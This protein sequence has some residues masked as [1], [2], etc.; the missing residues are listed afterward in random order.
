LKIQDFAKRKLRIEAEIQLGSTVALSTTS[1][2]TIDVA[3]ILWKIGGL[4]KI[5]R[6]FMAKYKFQKFKKW[7]NF[8]VRWIG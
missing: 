7:E 3:H 1:I 8:V 4:I 2:T 5:C 6:K